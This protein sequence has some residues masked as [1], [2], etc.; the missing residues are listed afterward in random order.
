MHHSRWY[1]IKPWHIWEARSGG[2]PGGEK[3]RSWEQWKM[4]G[5]TSWQRQV[6]KCEKYS[7][8]YT[9]HKNT[10][11]NSCYKQIPGRLRQ[12]WFTTCPIPKWVL[13]WNL[14][15]S[16]CDSIC[17]MGWQVWAEVWVK[18]SSEEFSCAVCLTPSSALQTATHCMSHH[19]FLLL[20][21]GLSPSCVSRD[22]FGA[23][24]WEFMDTMC[25]PGYWDVYCM[26]I[27]I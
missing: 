6:K 26:N 3:G 19:M 22:P 2:I 27:F 9:E 4:I 12:C 25:W 8:W 21:H 17:M 10:V 15:L 7:R 16:C 1:F 24:L 20:S 18:E 14:Q 11:K 13:P 23:A 5:M